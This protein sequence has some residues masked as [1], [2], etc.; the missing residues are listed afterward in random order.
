MCLLCSL[1]TICCEFSTE[2]CCVV[3][4]LFSHELPIV[5]IPVL[6]MHC[7][8]SFS[9]PTTGQ[10]KFYRPWTITNSLFCTASLLVLTAVLP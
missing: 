7:I 9:E 3:L 2:E 1:F 6:D 8:L 4:G 10:I 5:V